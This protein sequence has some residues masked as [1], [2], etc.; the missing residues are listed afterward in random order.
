[1][2]S[3]DEQGAIALQTL[4]GNDKLAA[5]YFERN[6]STLKTLWPLDGLLKSEKP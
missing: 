3:E 2:T 5:K 1:M 4:L 6:R